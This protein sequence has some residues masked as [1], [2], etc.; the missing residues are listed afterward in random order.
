[1]YIEIIDM[2]IFK[3]RVN[4]W[5]TY[6]SKSNKN[7]VDQHGPMKDNNFPQRMLEYWVDIENMKIY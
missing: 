6:K 5:D 2:D 1:M 4:N 7:N 3:N